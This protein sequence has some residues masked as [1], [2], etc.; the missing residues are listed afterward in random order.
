MGGYMGIRMIEEEQN[1]GSHTVIKVIGIGGGGSNAVNRMI[2]DG[3]TSVEFIVMNT[4]VQ[5]LHSNSAPVRLPLGQEITGGLGAGGKPD[6]GEQ[7]ALEDRQNIH[8]VLEG[9]DMVFLTAGMGGGTGTGAMPVV[10]SVAKELGILCVAVLTKPFIFEG[11]WKMRLAEDGI[12]KLRAA[13]DTLI[14]ISNERLLKVA[15]AQTAVLDA[16]RI[17]DDVLRQGVQ[18]ISDLITKEGI[19][20]IDFA[21][22]KTIMSNRGDALM[23]IGMGSGE[24]RVM[25]AAKQAIH[26]PMLENV[27]INGATGLLLNICGGNDFSL[28]EYNEVLSFI[29]ATASKTAKIISGYAVDPSLDDKLQVNVIA[30][31]FYAEADDSVMEEVAAGDT[32]YVNYHEWANISG[33]QS[34]VHNSVYDRGNGLFDSETPAV[35]RLKK[36]GIL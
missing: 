2:Q 27:H 29:T 35:V 32:E 4:D 18:G 34:M 15:G 33:E 7:A 5:A 19:I 14:V 8:R 23:G 9:A 1:N 3:V 16:F 12:E 11:E 10:A 30:T 6:V 31:G 36:N 13:V 17:A 25:D 21:D 20:N 24:N 22:V 28:S 26:N